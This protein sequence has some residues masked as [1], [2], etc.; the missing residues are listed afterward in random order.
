MKKQINPSIKAQILRSAFI[1]LSLV[2]VC[3]IP[4]ALGQRTTTKQSAVAPPLLLGSAPVSP[5]SGNDAPST[6][7]NTDGRF[8]PSTDSWMETGWMD[9]PRARHTATLLSSGKVMVVAGY[10]VAE[11]NDPAGYLASAEVYD[12]VTGS[13]SYTGSL[14]AA[15]AD[16]TATLLPRERC[17][18][19]GDTMAAP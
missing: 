5:L 18:W 16:H 6:F 14:S 19:R 10:K 11:F 15:R 8:S 4:F 13:W 3:V 2:A 12:P 17:W 7:D 9:R 1:L